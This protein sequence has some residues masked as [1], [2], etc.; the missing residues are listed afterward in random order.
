MIISYLRSFG[1]ASRSELNTLVQPK[2][3]DVL[4]EE[5]KKRKV[6]NF[7]S[8]LKKKGIIKLTDGKRW[9]LVEV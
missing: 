9:V 5:Q 3:S 2:L 6:G 7:L 4:T 8:T 1:G